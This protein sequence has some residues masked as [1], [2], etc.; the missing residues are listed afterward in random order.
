MDHPT[1]D[2]SDLSEFQIREAAL[3]LRAVTR[4]TP[5]LRCDDEAF[6]SRFVVKAENM[7]VSGSFAARSAYT[8]LLRLPP[9]KRRDGVIC[10]STGGNWAR[11]VAW[12][13]L[14]FD[15]HATVVIPWHLT[16]CK[17]ALAKLGAHIVTYDP[18]THN[19]ARM[20]RDLRVQRGLTSVEP[21]GMD[22]IY[23]AGTAAWEM[24]QAMPSLAAIVVPIGT[25]SLAAGTVIAASTHRPHPVPV[26]GVEPVSADATS[27]SLNA[28]RL[29][30]ITPPSD[31]AT[32]LDC[33][34]ARNALTINRRLLQAVVTADTRTIHQAM[35]WLHTHYLT[36]AGPAGAVALAGAVLHDHDLPPGLIGVIC[37][38][39]NGGFPP[40]HRA[41]T[42]HAC[43]SPA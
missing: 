21:G 28:Q 17:D 27:R 25:G 39:A 40:A 14:Y 4:T 13:A 34:P 31:L 26:F 43:L 12:A 5:L 10:H 8:A 35:G 22:A 6:G 1:S 18:R 41:P 37:T 2:L 9:A 11:A 38:G 30:P 32:V 36:V 7:Q 23:G 20:A 3:D 16:N 42:N 29:L 19:G 33:P 24:L 15:V